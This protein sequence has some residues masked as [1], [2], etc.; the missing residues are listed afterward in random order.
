MCVIN[1]YMDGVCMEYLIN[2]AVRIY[3]TEWENFSEMHFPQT[4]KP[5]DR[6]KNAVCVR[7]CM[8][9]VAWKKTQFALVNGTFHTC[10]PMYEYTNSVYGL[11]A[12]VVPNVYFI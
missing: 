4:R 5:T 12:F 1:I 2:S 9:A 6:E 3:E 11:L 8:F 10:E 7:K